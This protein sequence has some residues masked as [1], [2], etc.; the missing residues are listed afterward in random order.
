MK[1]YN[2]HIKVI[3]ATENNEDIIVLKFQDFKG[4]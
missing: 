4:E 1:D 2:K 3:K